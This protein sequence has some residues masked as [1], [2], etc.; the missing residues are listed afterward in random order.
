[1]ASC[2]PAIE[3]PVSSGTTSGVTL[4]TFDYISPEQARDP[5]TAD[6]RSDIYSLGCTLYHMLTGDPPYPEGTVLQKLLQHQGDEAPDP[7]PKNDAVP[8][9]LSVVVRR[10]MAKDPRR[11]YQTAEQLVRDMMLVADGMGLK[12]VS[13][14]GLVWLSPETERTSFWQRHLAWVSTVAV[15]LSIVVYLEYVASGRVGR[16]PSSSEISPRRDAREE[17]RSSAEETPAPPEESLDNADRTTLE[18]TESRLRQGPGARES[19]GGPIAAESSSAERANR[20]SNRVEPNG[21]DRESGEPGISKPI[22]STEAIRTAAEGASAPGPQFD[23][24]QSPAR[25][26]TG[27]DVPPRG[28]APARRIESGSK[29]EDEAGEGQVT[30]EK[31]APDA[32]LAGASNSGGNAT[33]R[34][35][36]HDVSSAVLAEESGIFLLGREGASDRKFLTLEAACSE[37]RHDGAVI[38]LRFDGRRSESSLKITRKVTIRAGRGRRP[39]IEFRPTQV[40]TDGYRIRAVSIPSGSL[41]LVGVDLALVV[42]DTISAEHVSLFSIE[43]PESLRLHGVTVTVINPRPNAATLV[44]MRPTA[45]ALMP[46]MPTVGVPSLEIEIAD[47]LLRGQC[48]LFVVRHCEPARIALRNCVVAVQGSLLSGQGSTETSQENAQLE[49]K[50]EHVTAALGGGLIKLDCGNLPRRLAP[51][52]VYASGSIF[53]NPG[54][55]SFVAM[56]GNSPPQDFRM[57]LSWNGRNNIYDRYSTFWSIVSVEG[58]GRIENWDFSNW[59]RNWTETAEGNARQVDGGIWNRRQWMGKSSADLSAADFSLDRQMPGNPA[60]A[61]ATSSTDAGAN[62]SIIPHPAGDAT[63]ER[64]RD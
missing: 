32:T 58:T 1:L 47:S 64:P 37:I 12:S 20:Q 11:R 59:R 17:D 48:D 39:M 38:E 25:S 8:R 14:E 35:L 34:P 30:A 9:D 40:V 33:S 49:L 52:Q 15:L 19:A 54:G 43:R 61:G 60:V 22:Q 46:D 10:M 55:A 6:V 29:R 50:L 51:V 18:R 63:A 44:E 2:A 28:T 41:D 24:A 36:D 57:L 3:A 5:R 13:A 7:A 27:A 53:S 45:G 42:D 16:A 31:S 26:T 62:L 21:D 4:G 56:T 23:S